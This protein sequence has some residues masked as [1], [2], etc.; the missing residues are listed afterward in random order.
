MSSY[1]ALSEFAA[2]HGLDA[3]GMIR[4]ASR[5]KNTPARVQAGTKVQAGAKRAATNITAA[6][7]QR[8]L[9]AH[10]TAQARADNRLYVRVF[11]AAR[12]AHDVP[13]PRPGNLTTTATA[14][15]AALT[16]AEADRLY[17]Q[18]FGKE[19]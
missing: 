1:P 12:A 9:D 7:A 10:A 16:P 13:V 19:S 6:E 15:G 5:R 3:E 4:M 14:A 11:G 2:R 17:D 18:L 8:Q